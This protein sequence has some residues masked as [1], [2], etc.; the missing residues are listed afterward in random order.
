[1]EIEIFRIMAGNCFVQKEIYPTNLP[2]KHNY[3]SKD[4]HT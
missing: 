2:N 3:F 4:I 1:M